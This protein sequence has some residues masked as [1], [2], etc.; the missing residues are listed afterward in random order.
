M[1]S[2]ASL[3]IKNDTTR[4][5]TTHVTRDS[6]VKNDGKDVN[7]K[8]IP[9]KQE[10]TFRIEAKT[11]H[12][13]ELDIDLVEGLN[14]VVGQLKINSIK[15]PQKDG[16]LETKSYR[17]Y[18]TLSA[19]G[20]RNSD[21]NKDLRRIELEI[22][23]K[24]TV[25][26][27]WD[28]VYASQIG[29]INKQLKSIFEPLSY[30]GLNIS[31]IELVLSPTDRQ[32]IAQVKVHIE[33]GIKKILEVKGDCSFTVN[34]N[35]IQGSIKGNGGESY[36]LTIDFTECILEQVNLLNLE[37]TNPLGI[38]LP[39]QKE[40]ESMI[41]EVVNNAFGLIEPITMDFDFALPITL[42]GAIVKL[43]FVNNS[44]EPE[45]SFLSF[46]VGHKS[47]GIYNLSKDVIANEENCNTSFVLSNAVIM[48]YLKKVLTEVLIDN[49]IYIGDNFLELDPES[50][51][52]KLKSIEDSEEFKQQC[53]VKV[54]I[55]KGG[56]TSQFAKKDG[57]SNL[58]IEVGIRYRTLLKLSWHTFPASL[59]INFSAQDEKLKLEFSEEIGDCN[60]SHADIIVCPKVKEAVKDAINQFNKRFNDGLLI[61]I[62]NLSVHQV[63]APSYIQISGKI[64]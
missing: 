60:I 19:D 53:D 43:A 35:S 58:K 2:P 56:L 30:K 38:P 23:N 6:W 5:I 62:A 47:D 50:Y 34:L 49:D 17:D 11:N 4:E 25:T 9:A 55:D 10:E 44:T 8:L 36:S 41:I 51:P 61:S 54:K 27:G 48:T 37:V 64:E 12:H 13:G 52:L 29:V 32:S 21:G 59:F 42:D 33:G 16:A 22:T 31:R 39:S 28:F 57:H 3:T 40:I 24:P 26:S 18:I 1:S 63:A 45:R 7:N 46:L 20:Y 14:Q 15:D